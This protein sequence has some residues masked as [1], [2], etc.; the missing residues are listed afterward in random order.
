MLSVKTGC[1]TPTC[2]SGLCYSLQSISLLDTIDPAIDPRICCIR[3]KVLFI[4][5]SKASEKENRMGHNAVIAETE[6]RLAL[7]S[8]KQTNWRNSQ[9]STHD[10]QRMG[11]AN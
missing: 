3:G 4:N 1:Q 11:R 2:Y 8:Q 10:N 5:I 7:V 9:K 6:L